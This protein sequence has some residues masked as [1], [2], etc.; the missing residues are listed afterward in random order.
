ML[1]EMNLNPN[2]ENVQKIIERRTPDSIMKCMRKM[3]QNASILGEGGN[4]QVFAIED[5]ELSSV[6]VKKIKEKQQILANNIDTEADFQDEAMR[7]GVRVPLLLGSY[8]TDKKEHFIIMQRIKGN[9]L[10]EIFVQPKLLPKKFDFE[11]FVQDLDHQI[12]LLHQA[13]IYHRDLH[14]RNIMMD[15]E[16]MPVIIDFGTAT[17]GTGSDLTYEESVMM[18]NKQMNRYE[19]KSGYFK[20]DLEMIRNLKSELRKLVLV[21][22]QNTKKLKKQI[23]DK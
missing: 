23:I 10:A 19:Q 20:D 16:G 12:T 21:K 18:Y 13:G 9:S 14:S 3:E 2:L 11:V 5:S 1:R 15:K 22:K 17:Y 8:T 6:C 4:A 7:A